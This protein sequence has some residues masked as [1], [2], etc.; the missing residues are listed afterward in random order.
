ML[1]L[2]AGPPK[3]ARELVPHPGWMGNMEHDIRDAYH[4]RVNAI[5][6]T[7]LFA[8]RELWPT[9]QKQPKKVSA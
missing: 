9:N 5:Q 3:A 6:I 1:P 4:M 7:L 2:D 8:P